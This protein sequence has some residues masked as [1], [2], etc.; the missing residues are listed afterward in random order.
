MVGAA[1][2]HDGIGGAGPGQEAGVRDLGR[3]RP[4]GEAHRR[5]GLVER[6]FRHPLAA[7]VVEG[8]EVG[9]VLE[10]A[11]VAGERLSVEG[12][13]VE[14]EPVAVVA[15]DGE[16]GREGDVADRVG[17]C[18]GILRQ[19]APSA[20]PRLPGASRLDGHAPAVGAAVEKE[21]LG[22][23]PQRQAHRRPVAQHGLDGGLGLEELA[24]VVI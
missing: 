3:E 16:L 20:P 14:A 12:A 18:R 15:L 6:P 7:D 1:G 11:R 23:A 22:V 9:V 17:R 2:Q 21:F 4:A 10:R 5:R 19:H 8:R 24:A 13:R